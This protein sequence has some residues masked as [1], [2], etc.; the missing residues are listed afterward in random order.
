MLSPETYLEVLKCILMGSG[1]L[2]LQLHDYGQRSKKLVY[3]VVHFF[4][5]FLNDHEHLF[6]ECLPRQF[7][8]RGSL[9]LLLQP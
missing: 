5:P 8:S 9:S 7:H 4:V 3:R 6:L 1:N 2:T